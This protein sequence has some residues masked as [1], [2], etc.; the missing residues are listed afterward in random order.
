MRFFQTL[1]LAAAAVTLGAHA[2]GAQT[3]ELLWP[4]GARG[5]VGNEDVDKPSITIYPAPA[6]KA[7]GTG[8]IVF[9]G[10]G[11]THL[12]MD[13]EGKQIAEWLNSHGIAAFVSTYRL[14]P[15][16]HYPAPFQD[17]QRAIRIV[18]SRAAEFAVK[19]DPR[20]RRA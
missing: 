20:T 1:L 8:I 3:T 17:A 13:H 12:A 19:P 14:G 6:G 11:Y 16:Y 4:G 5:A 7:T 15:R 10:G 18:R 9:P 2:L